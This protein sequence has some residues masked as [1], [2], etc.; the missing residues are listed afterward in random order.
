MA[1]AGEVEAHAAGLEREQEQLGPAGILLEAIHHGLAFAL[2]G[3]A[4]EE[5]HLLTPAAFQVRL[6]QQPPFGE[7]GEQQGPIARLDHL[8]ED[9][10]QPLHLGAAGREAG[11]HPL[12][13]E[14][15]GGVVADLLELREQGQHLAVLL[16]QGGAGDRIEALL[17][18]FGVKL[19]LL[20][21]EAHPFAQLH[22]LGQVGDDRFVGLEAAQDEGAH[23]GLEVP[24]GA[25]VAVA[26]DRQA[27]ALAEEG[28]I[29]QHPGVEEVHQGP[30][31]ADAVLH[32]RAGE[33]DAEA[34]LLAGAAEVAGGLALLGGGIL[35]R[36]GLIDHHPLPVDRFEQLAVA[37]E[38]AIAGEHQ[39]D[40]VEGLPQGRLRGGAAGAVV[41][42]HPQLRREA[43]RL[44]FP[45]GEHRGGGHQQH[46]PPQFLLR[47]EVLQE[48]QQLDRLAQAHVVGQTGAL[49]EAVQEGQPAQAPLLIGPQLAREALR[50]R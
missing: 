41:L 47:L 23:P 34:A 31:L 4:V 45:V 28:F 44:P 26:L 39:V 43:R 38:Q 30:E 18:R 50:R 19:L 1:G 2:A 35:D 16:A 8:L 27:V 14:G 11:I 36:L 33:G 10:L 40:T 3:V 21:A 12:L 42:P 32:R 7:L 22:L 9:L 49:V 6:E 20:G 25:H 24:Q 13:L 5:G 46:G 17:H 15:Q 37:L 29:P 48:G